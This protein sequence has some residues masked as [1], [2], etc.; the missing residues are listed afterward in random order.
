M[1][2]EDREY[3]RERERERERERDRYISIS[4]AFTGER[5]KRTLLSFQQE[6]IDEGER[7]REH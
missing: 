3:R 6:E 2:I 5:R 4:K 1:P 7:E